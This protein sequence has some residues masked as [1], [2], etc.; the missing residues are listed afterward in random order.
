MKTNKPGDQHE[1]LSKVLKEWRVDAPLPERFQELV[2]RRIEG[3]HA[4]A[5]PS[6]WTLIAHW[7]GTVLPRPAL[8]V[9][10]LTVLLAIGVAAGWAQARRRTT[11]VNHEL[12]QRYFRVLDPYQTPRK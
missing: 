2:L 3:G 6:I 7:I 11:R 5:I 8:A 10:Y 12:G 1:A 9:S 4:P